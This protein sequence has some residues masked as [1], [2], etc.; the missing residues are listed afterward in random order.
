[1]KDSLLK[2]EDL[3]LG[4]MVQ[5]RVGNERLWFQVDQPVADTVINAVVCRL[6]STPISGIVFDGQVTL[7]REWIIDVYRAPEPNGSVQ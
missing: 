7:D 4:D 3:G 6:H 5:A 2:F 1:M